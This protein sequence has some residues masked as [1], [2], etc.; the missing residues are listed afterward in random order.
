MSFP[1]LDMR[2][3][4]YPNGLTTVKEHGHAVQFLTSIQR[5]PE[6][7]LAAVRWRDGYAVDYLTP[8]Q[9]TPVVCL[10]A[11]QQNW[12][13][14]DLFSAAE[15]AI[16]NTWVPELH[17]CYRSRTR[18]LIEVSLEVSSAMLPL[19]ESQL[20]DWIETLEDVLV[21]TGDKYQL[22]ANA[23]NITPPPTISALLK[24]IKKTSV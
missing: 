18:R 8:E 23:D 3:T 15:M 17:A 14:A 24:D 5:T 22:C 1:L 2:Y 20:N 19:V 6:V 4:I 12:Q 10:A 11:L 16:C 13:T 9:R 21:W 7:C